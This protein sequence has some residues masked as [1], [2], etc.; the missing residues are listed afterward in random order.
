MNKKIMVTGASSG[1]GEMVCKYLSEQGYYVIM[2]AR[3]EQRLKRVSDE[4]TSECMILPYDLQNLMDIEE[5]IQKATVGG[6][7]HG[8][9]HC[10]GVNRD[11]PVKMNDVQDMKEVMTINYY[12]FVELAK[13]FY[14]KRYSENG[15]SIIAVSSM[16]AI[17]CS[18]GMCNYSASKEALNVAVKVMSKEFSK[19]KIRVNSIM[20]GY[21]DTPM[22]SN[23]REQG[24]FHELMK[25]QPL[26]L[27]DPQQ[28]AYL[29][30]FLLSDKSISVT[31]ANIPITGGSN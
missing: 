4:L 24:N 31:G 18:K 21:V 12:S 5:L 25:G 26:G 10:A 2:V 27:I 14:R 8:L 22:L 11:V 6:K 3:N 29:I 19:R 9:V 1:I 30:E 13:Y 28:V 16:A 7:L 20:P 15:A 17:A 23:L